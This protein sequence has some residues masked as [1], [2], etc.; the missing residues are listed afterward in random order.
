M[1]IK[2][3]NMVYVNDHTFILFLYLTYVDQLFI[4]LK[5]KLYILFNGE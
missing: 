2:I 4:Y 1:E 5:Y 3:D